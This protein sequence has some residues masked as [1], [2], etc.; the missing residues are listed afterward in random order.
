MK[1]IKLL[2]ILSLLSGCGNAEI[3]A[4]THKKYINDQISTV[5]I[6]HIEYIEDLNNPFKN[7]IAVS[8]TLSVDKN[9][10]PVQCDY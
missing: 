9:G 8:I 5:C 3:N 2:I 10:K 7:A 4:E 6:N 1:L